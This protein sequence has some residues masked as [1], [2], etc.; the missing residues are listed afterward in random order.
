MLKDII[1]HGQTTNL[2][3]GHIKHTR[4]SDRWN[5]YFTKCAYTKKCTP[6]ITFAHTHTPSPNK[7]ADTCLPCIHTS[8]QLCA[9]AHLNPFL[10]HMCA[11][12]SHTPHLIL[13]HHTQPT[14]YMHS[15]HACMH[16]LSKYHATNT[17][18]RSSKILKLS[19]HTEKLATGIS[20][21]VP[22][23]L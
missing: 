8:L 7:D 17:S 20:N 19:E 10:T 13:V 9:Q 16:S 15:L 2:Q 6:T 18:W 11:S 23:A 5:T 4:T 12:L 1:Q 14:I 22:V 21:Q 3:T